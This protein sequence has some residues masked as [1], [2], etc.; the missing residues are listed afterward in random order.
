ME[1]LEPSFINCKDTSNSDSSHK[2][3]MEVSD[4]TLVNSEETLINDSPFNASMEVSNGRDILSEEIP[5]IGMRFSSEEDVDKFYRNY[6]MKV[7]FGVKIVALKGTKNL[8]KSSTGFWLAHER[9]II[10]QISILSRRPM[11]PL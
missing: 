1:E 4:Q 7:G 6:A 8:E 10:S 9:G 11:L 2:I 5:V 3:A